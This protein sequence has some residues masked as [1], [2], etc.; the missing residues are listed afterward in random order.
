MNQVTKYAVV[1]SLAAV[2][3]LSAVPCL[4][5]DDTPQSQSAPASKPAREVITKAVTFMSVIMLLLLAVAVGLCLL[6]VVQLLFPGLTSCGADAMRKGLFRSFLLGLAVFVVLVLL[7]AGASAVAKPLGDALG[8]VLLIL[9]ALITFPMVS[10]DLGRRIFARSAA[11]PGPVG[12]L[13]V[14][15]LVFAGASIPGFFIIF[16]F[17][18]LAG[19]GALVQ[20]FWTRKADQPAAETPAAEIADEQSV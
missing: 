11:N 6:I 2:V 9:L 3:L 12:Q 16:P 17:L 13:A 1:F 7:V 20:T 8:G 19:I 4:A 5:T 14:G 10:Q 18:T 15:W